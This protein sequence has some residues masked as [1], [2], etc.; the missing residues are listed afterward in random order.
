MPVPSDTEVNIIRE[1]DIALAEIWPVGGK[2]APQRRPSQG[3]GLHGKAKAKI[4]SFST[5]PKSISTHWKQTIFL[6]REPIYLDEGV[7]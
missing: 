2:S 5:S 1:G 4:T 3:E 7:F 6:F